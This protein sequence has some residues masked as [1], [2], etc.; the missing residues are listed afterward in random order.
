MK[1]A[2]N[3]TGKPNIIAFDVSV[4]HSTA[5]LRVLHSTAVPARRHAAHIIVLPL[6]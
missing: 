4:L 3:Y 6:M 5:V 2:R 1:I